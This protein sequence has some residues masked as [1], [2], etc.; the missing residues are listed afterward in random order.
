MIKYKGK[1]LTEEQESHVL[2]ITSTG[3]DYAIQAPPGSGKTFLLLALARK[4]KGYGLS[5]SF[6]KILAIEAGNKFCSSVMCKTGH[7]LA[8]GSVGYKY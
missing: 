8:F 4:M 3:K 1:I 5:I 6:N 2:T 7:A